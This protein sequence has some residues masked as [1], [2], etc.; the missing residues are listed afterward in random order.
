MRDCCSLEKQLLSG[1]TPS[2]WCVHLFT[3][4]AYVVSIDFAHKGVATRWLTV[5]AFA[6][7]HRQLFK[8]LLSNYIYIYFKFNTLSSLSTF[9]GI[10]N[11]HKTVY[12]SYV[13][14]VI[15]MLLTISFKCKFWTRLFI[16]T[17]WNHISMLIR[18]CYLRMQE[19]IKGFELN[20]TIE[21]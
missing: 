15:V 5:R 10:Q 13:E 7:Q 6:S 21:Y 19:Q 16:A 14:H 1:N 2:E 20:W 8:F 4:C 17:I 3:L 9:Y 18:L 11:K 12:Y